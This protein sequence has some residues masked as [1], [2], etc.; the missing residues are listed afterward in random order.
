[1]SLYPFLAPILIGVVMV[2]GSLVALWMVREADPYK[3]L[4]HAGR[5]RVGVIMMMASL[6]ASW[7]S[8]K[9]RRK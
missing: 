2:A 6:C 7:R 4:P 9:V 3:P 5:R 8:R 1:M